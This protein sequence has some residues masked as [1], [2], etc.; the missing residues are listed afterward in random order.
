MVANPAKLEGIV[1]AA[2]FVIDLPGTIVGRMDFSELSGINSK[3]GSSE[4]LYSNSDGTLVHTK[5]FG[6][7]EP[8]TITLKRAVD[9]TG[10]NRLLIWHNLAREGKTDARC[11]GSL[12]VF[13][14]GDGDATAIYFIFNAW[15]S[16]LTISSLKAGSSDVA[17]VECKITCE[18]IEGK[19]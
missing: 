15:C 14:A 12:S 17:S 8:P 6:K 13:G 16:D 11:D 19:Q 2:R 9:R 7:T 4:Y 3:V 5:Q 1:S 10:T 18:R